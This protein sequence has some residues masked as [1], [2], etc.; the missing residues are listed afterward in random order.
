MDIISK[1]SKKQIFILAACCVLGGFLNGLIGAAG[2]IL[3]T[4]ALTALLSKDGKSACDSKTILS[5]VQLA[6]VCISLV[7]LSV[8]SA[9]GDIVF[10]SWKQLIVP[11][12]LGG[13]AGCFLQKRFS[14]KII[15]SIFTLLVIWSGI[16]MV[17]G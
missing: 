6:I 7:S 15:S 8:Y 17:M 11:S 5:N 16:R 1:L 4:I 14:S 3:I 12:A 9:R 2:G 13:L 10:S